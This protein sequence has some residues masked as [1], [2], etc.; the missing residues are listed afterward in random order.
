M[1]IP[2][3]ECIDKNPTVFLRPDSVIQILHQLIGLLQRIWNPSAEC[4]LPPPSTARA[5]N[6]AAAMTTPARAPDDMAAATTLAARRSTRTATAIT[7]AVNQ[8]RWH[9][10]HPAAPN[11]PGRLYS[12]ASPSAS[13][14]LGQ[15]VVQS[16]KNR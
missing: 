1:P 3:T 6:F 12:P 14:E 13:P 5:D 8:P 2:S 16:S 11:D 15:R 10:K 4:A 7:G 9:C